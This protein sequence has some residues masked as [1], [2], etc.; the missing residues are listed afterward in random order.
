MDKELRM[1]NRRSVL[2]SLV[3]VAFAAFMLAWPGQAV[4]G[5]G[6]EGD[7]PKPGALVV[8]V[9]DAGGKPV[10]GAHVEVKRGDRT[11][12]QGHTNREGKFLVPRL[13]PGKF[14]VLAGKREVGRG[15]ALAEVLSEKKNEVKVVLKK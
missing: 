9:F 13:H 15:R 5:P 4:A 7:P 10:L 3:A 2:A 12:A 6:T 14:A 11:V 1:S 8:S